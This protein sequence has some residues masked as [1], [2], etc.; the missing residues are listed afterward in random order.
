MAEHCLD[1]GQRLENQKKRPVPVV[2]AGAVALSLTELFVTPAV[3]QKV[4]T[5]APFPELLGAVIGFALLLMLVSALNAYL[6]NITSLGRIEV[7]I[8]L[9]QQVGLKYEMTS[10]PN[11][12]DPAVLKKMEKANEAMYGNTTASEAVWT[13]L[14]KNIAGFVIYLALLS[15][16]DPVLL[17]V[18]LA[19]TV[20][21]FFVSQRINQ[22]GYRHREEE[23]AYLK[24]L[25]YI[26]YKAPQRALGKDIRI[27]GLRPWL[28]DVF[29]SAMRLYSDFIA[30]REKVYL[31]ADVVDVLLSFARNG[32]AYV[33][34]ITMALGQ[35]LPASQFLLYFTAIGGFTTWIT[36]IL[37]GFSTLN[38]QSMDLSTI[39]EFLEIPELFLF[40]DGKPLKAENIPYEIAGHSPRFEP[41]HPRRG[42]AGG[43][44]PK[45]RR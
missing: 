34:L 5:A 24:K 42:K 36:G 20:V 13:T 10:F 38:L 25:N 18:V 37:A 6:G 27:F 35:G 33:Y 30:R 43:G 28:Q 39:R 17:I 12:E 8:A 1:D 23:S 26:T 16:L 11:T 2:A 29:D 32:I 31:W 19:T 14:L 9:L 44:G 45:R 40:E 22:W 15:S 4:E 41:D 3:L 7:R 21:G